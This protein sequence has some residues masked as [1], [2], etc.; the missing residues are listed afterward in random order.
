M[1]KWELMMQKRPIVKNNPK[2]N[3]RGLVASWECD[4]PPV[5]VQELED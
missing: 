5:A 4:S 2:A 3:K 1:Y